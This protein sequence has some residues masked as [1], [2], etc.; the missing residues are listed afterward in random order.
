MQR[1]LT[2]VSAGTSGSILQ[3]VGG[4]RE[5]AG[6]AL[7]AASA[8]MV[9]SPRVPPQETQLTGLATLLIRLGSALTSLTRGC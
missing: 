2:E 4:G 6:R 1:L 3:G 8:P 7:W 5:G 9:F